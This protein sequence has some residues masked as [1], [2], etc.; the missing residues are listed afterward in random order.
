M[1]S[2]NSNQSHS[3]RC[4]R[5]N[6]KF[7]AY[8]GLR[9][10]GECRENILI[11][12]PYSVTPKELRRIGAVLDRKDQWARE[13]WDTEIVDERGQ[14]VW[15]RDLAKRYRKELERRKHGDFRS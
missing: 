4:K 13:L 7:R 15:A 3:K 8:K 1:H 9:Y 2:Q 14:V 5:C 6:K 11:E 10:C 12:E